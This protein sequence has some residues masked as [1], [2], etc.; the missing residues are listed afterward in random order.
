M[1]LF[2]YKP[3]ARIFFHLSLG[4]RLFLEEIKDRYV[5]LALQEQV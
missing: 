4:R 1:F 5:A 3:M 2:L